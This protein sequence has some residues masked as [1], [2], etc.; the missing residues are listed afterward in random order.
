MKT[1]DLLNTYENSLK[2]LDKSFDKCINNM[3][4]VYKAHKIVKGKLHSE[5]EEIER[6][7]K[8]ANNY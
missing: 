6:M 2:E 7:I 5:I 4:T 3:M 1:E 8:K